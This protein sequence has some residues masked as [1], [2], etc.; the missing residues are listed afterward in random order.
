MMLRPRYLALA[1]V[2]LAIEIY[3][4][5][6][7]HDAFVRPYGGDFLVVILL[8]CL[9]RGVSKVKA[10][11]AALG[12]L[13]FAYAIETGQYFHVADRLGFT[14]P[15]LMRTLIGTYF[16]WIDILCYTLGI[17]LVMGVE[18]LRSR[19]QTP[20]SARSGAGETRSC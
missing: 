10:W 8:Y 16:T 7:M 19:R 15:S 9:V 3:I 14:R 6:C 2:L 5:A 17:L 11:P 20:S 12:A 4:G 18:T 1:A 13:V